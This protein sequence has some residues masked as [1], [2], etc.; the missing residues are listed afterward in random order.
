M[1]WRSLFAISQTALAT[2]NL[3]DGVNNAGVISP[4]EA[5]VQRQM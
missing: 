4:N 5:I 1:L 2:P 3:S